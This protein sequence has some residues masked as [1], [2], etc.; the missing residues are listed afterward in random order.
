MICTICGGSEQVIKAALDK[1]TY[2][3]CTCGVTLAVPMPTEEE[4]KAFYNTRYVESMGCGEEN[5]HFR[6][7]YQPIYQSEKAL[8]F[9]DLGFPHTEGVGLRWLDVGCANGLFVGWIQQFGYETKGVDVAPEMIEEARQKGLDCHC[10]EANDLGEVFDIVSLWDVIEHALDPDAMLSR[11]SSAVKSEGNLFLQTPCTGIISD[12]FGQGWREYTYPNHLH[13][14]SQDA[15]FRLLT[16]H[17]FMIRNWVRFGSGNTSGTLPDD[18][19]RVIDTI[20]KRMG[21]GDVIALWAVRT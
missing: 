17:G 1:V 10:C 16:R 7:E 18:K 21:I 11:V 15:L 20:A 14:F 19:K 9:R 13:L 12:T 5:P 3:Q 4:L 8:T 2:V 6:E